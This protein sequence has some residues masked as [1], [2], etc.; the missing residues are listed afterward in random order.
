MN[1]K[2]EERYNKVIYIIILLL[3]VAL[4][5]V[6]KVLATQKLQGKG[7]VNVI[8][9]VFQFIYTENR[10][11]AFGILQGKQFFFYLITFL[12]IAAIVYFLIRIPRESI[13]LP[14]GIVATFIMAGAIG[15]LIDRITQ[16]YVVD[17]I[18]FRPI[19]FPVF[20]VAD[21]YVTLGCIAF[22]I[23][24]L[25][26]YRDSDFNFIDPRKDTHVSKS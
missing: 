21:I 18:Y 6:T 3:A 9:N 2:K 5:R 26:V 24:V 7:E 15:N 12:V 10:G 14:I 19:D 4:D 11:A 22:A 13:Y 16:Q 1:I 17:F 20:N 25:F 23:L 8:G